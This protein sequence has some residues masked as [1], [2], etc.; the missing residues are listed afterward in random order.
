M[1]NSGSVFPS[2]FIPRISSDLV[3]PSGEPEV[4]IYI[5]GTYNENALIL[6]QAREVGVDSIFVAG[7][8]AYSPELIK[9]AGDA[10][11]GF[12]CTLMALPKSEQSS[13]IDSFTKIYRAKYNEEPN[14]YATYSY[15]AVSMVAQAI[16]D[17]GYIGEGIK[18]ALYKVIYDG[19]TGTTQF[20]Q[21]GEV[22]KP[23]SIYVVEGGSFKLLAWAPEF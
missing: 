9:I 4:V 18:N 2:V 17:G 20:D 3:S 23:Y 7:D 5:P 19:I 22:D 6:R 10:A 15:D 8:G 1:I 13:E 12:Y 16:K 11:E 21:Y 14:V